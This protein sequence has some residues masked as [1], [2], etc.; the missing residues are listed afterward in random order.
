MFDNTR[1]AEM[2]MSFGDPAFNRFQKF[3][4]EEVLPRIEG[5]SKPLGRYTAG[6]SNGGAWA[7]STAL[8]HPVLFRGALAFSPTGWKNVPANRQKTEQFV[9]IGSGT[10][11]SVYNQTQ[12]DAAQLRSIGLKTYAKFVVGG[13]SYS[14][15][16]ALFWWSLGSMT[17]T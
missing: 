1:S 9:W 2:V 14:T 5:G 10:L 17:K 16:N 12:Q 13:H 4:L 8:A 7:L 3:L 15:W 11:E 6:Y